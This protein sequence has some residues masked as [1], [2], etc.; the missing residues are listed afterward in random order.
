MHAMYMFG[1]VSVALA[2]EIYLGIYDRQALEI[3]KRF[4]SI[5]KQ[6]PEWALFY[7]LFLRNNYPY[8]VQRVFFGRI[9]HAGDLALLRR[10]K[11]VNDGGIRLV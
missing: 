6:A 10:C 1:P 8:L 4:L 9:D 2:L 11:G 5:T 3:E 7:S